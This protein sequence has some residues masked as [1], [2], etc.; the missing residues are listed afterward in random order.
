MSK[1]WEFSVLK[2]E[3]EP[4]PRSSL[5]CLLYWKGYNFLNKLLRTLGN[6]EN[7]FNRNMLVLLARSIFKLA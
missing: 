3:P 7:I 5:F 2:A 4:L 1:L 6:R